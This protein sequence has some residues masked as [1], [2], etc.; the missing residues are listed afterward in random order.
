[1]KSVDI[2]YETGFSDPH[3]FSFIFKKN[4]GVSPREYRQNPQTGKD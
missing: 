4:T 1:M 2:A 3:Y